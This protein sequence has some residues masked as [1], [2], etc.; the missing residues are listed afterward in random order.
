MRERTAG[1]LDEQSSCLFMTAGVFNCFV[2]KQ[3]F[4]DYNTFDTISYGILCI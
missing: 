2:D 1:G 3:P 4:A